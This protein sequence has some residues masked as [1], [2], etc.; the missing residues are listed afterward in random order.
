MTKKINDFRFKQ[1]AI[2]QQK[3]AMK[4]GTDGVLLGAWAT[5]NDSLR[6][7]DIGTGT[8]LIALMVA[9][10]TRDTQID[11]LEI[12]EPSYNE[13]KQNIENS[14][15]REQVKVY[16]SSLQSYSEHSIT[17]YSTI[18]SNPPFFNAGTHSPT[19]NRK[20][21][22]HTTQLPFEDLLSCSKKMLSQDGIMALIL[23]YIEGKSFITLAEKFHLY[24][25]RKTEFLS[26]EG[27]TP[28]RLLLELSFQ[29]KGMVE[30][31]LIHYDDNGEWTEDY[32]AVT[33]GFYLR[34]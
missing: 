11:A 19:L 9:Q 1:F 6:I 18:I 10:R 32:K 14:P 7:L 20:K 21:A 5:I 17:K 8:G 3:S 22:R 27:N 24:P 12:D 33:R 15:W 16:H 31:E 26:K 2:R 28:E 13:A 23:P 29:K 4:V 25:Q 30:D 34:L